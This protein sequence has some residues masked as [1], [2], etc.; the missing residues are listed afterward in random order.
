MLQAL[1]L[2]L[3]RKCQVVALN[4]TWSEIDF[5][6]LGPGWEAVRL[7]FVKLEKCTVW[8]DSFETFCF[9]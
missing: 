2:V 5:R 3:E 4:G 8:L 6:K 9:S 1:M 7:M